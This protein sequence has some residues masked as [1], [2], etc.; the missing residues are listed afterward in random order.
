MYSERGRI[1][2]IDEI[3][4]ETGISDFILQKAFKMF[5]NNRG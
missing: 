3:V 4:K 5:K 1:T 2:K